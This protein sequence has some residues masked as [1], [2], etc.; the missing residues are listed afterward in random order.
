VVPGRGAFR[1]VHVQRDD[2]DQHEQ[3]AEQAVE[4][5]LDRRVLPLADA[6]AADHEVHRHQHGLE[7]HV[8]QE[9]VGGREDADHHRLERHHQREV[10]LHAVLTAVGVVPGGQDRLSVVF[11]LFWYSTCTLQHN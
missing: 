2:R 1:R 11:L 5:E 10:R 9:D 3:P 7:E 4:Q 8:E 6:V